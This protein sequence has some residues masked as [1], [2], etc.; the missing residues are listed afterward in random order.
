LVVFVGLFTNFR[1][2]A[3]KYNEACTTHDT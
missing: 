2:K 1:K 3:I